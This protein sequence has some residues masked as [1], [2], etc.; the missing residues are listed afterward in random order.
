MKIM[1]KKNKAIITETI[2]LI[3]LLS[4]F[5]SA[6]VGVGISPAKA[7]FEIEG[8][9][10]QELQVLVFNS[11]DQ[12]PAEIHV[13]PQGAIASFTT[14]TPESQIVEQEPE[15]QRPIDNGKIFT[16]KFNPPATNEEKTYTG[17]IGAFSRPPP[18]AQ[19]GGNVGVSMTVEIKVTPTK[20]ILDFIT[21]THIL[22]AA[23]V[24]LA[25]L[26]IIAFR[27]AGFRIALEKEIREKKKKK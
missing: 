13:E 24:V 2:L 3:I 19:F 23:A 12:G 5:A 9:Q 18:G 14:V 16:V 22:I 10:T 17:Y 1:N 20:S 26:L 11:G 8:G 15:H 4:S 25:I 7:I 21:T 6:S 27:R